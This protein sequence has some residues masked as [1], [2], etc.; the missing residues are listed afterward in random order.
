MGDIKILKQSVTAQPRKLTAVWSIGEITSLT[1]VYNPISGMSKTEREDETIRRLKAPPR[2]VY[3]VEDE[4]A[5]VFSASICA[6]IDAEI[7]NSINNTL[8]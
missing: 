3:S 7:L 4:I 2:A 6:E 1:D 8:F 5:A